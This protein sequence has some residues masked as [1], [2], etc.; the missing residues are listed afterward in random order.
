MRAWAGSGATERCP[1]NVSDERPMALPAQKPSL[2]S[3]VSLRDSNALRLEDV[4]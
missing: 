2:K 4:V 3:R 1:C